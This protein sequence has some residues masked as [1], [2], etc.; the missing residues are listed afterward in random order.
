MK[1]TVNRKNLVSTLKALKELSSKAVD[2]RFIDVVSLIAQEDGL[3]VSAAAGAAFVSVLLEAEI[4]G[5]GTC[6]VGF[7]IYELLKAVKDEYAV[8]SFNKNLIITTESGLR[9]SIPETNK[10]I[11]IATLKEKLAG[12][13]DKEFTVNTENVANLAEIS[14]VFKPSSTLR[15]MDIISDGSRIYG[16]VQGSEF[17]VLENLPMEGS[18]DTL[19]ITMRPEHVTPILSFCGEHVR[20]SSVVGVEGVYMLTDPANDSWWAAIQQANKPGQAKE[21]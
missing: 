7:K 17:G 4:V 20:L 19:S 16:A 6:H 21:N 8:L 15:W 3:L 11:P 5:E 14:K 9:A 2:E 18:G 10:A 12:G 1:I 13:V